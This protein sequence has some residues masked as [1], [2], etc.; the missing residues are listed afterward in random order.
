VQAFNQYV[1]LYNAEHSD[2][3]AAGTLVPLEYSSCDFIVKASGIESHFVVDKQGILDPRRMR[4]NIPER[5]DE[6]L[7]L[8]GE[9]GVSAAKQALESA[10]R[11]AQ[12]IDLVIVAC[13]NLQ[14]A[15][16]AISIEIQQHLDCFGYGY[17]MN[18]ACS[19]AAKCS[20]S[21]CLWSVA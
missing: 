17:D 11:K 18:V 16:P 10:G 4:P 1:D 13:S 7:S 12:E 3:I 15:Y 8:L 19:S 14:R 9:T 5:G 2:E 21:Y 6:S 20:R